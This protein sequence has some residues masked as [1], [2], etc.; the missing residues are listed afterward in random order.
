M[1]L[2]FISVDQNIYL[3]KQCRSRWG[4]SWRAVLSDPEII[5]LF[6]CSAQLSLKFSLLI[7]MKKSTI[8]GIFIFISRESFMLSYFS[9]KE[10]GMIVSNL[11]FISMKKFMLSWVE[12][13]KS[14]IT[15]GPDLRCLTFDWHPCL[16]YYMYRK[17]KT[18]EFVSVTLWR[19]DWRKHLFTRTNRL[20]MPQQAV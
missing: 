17:S 13:E 19:K 2:A 6:S 14:F 8:V 11:R 1:G 18:E 3:C 15:S 4:G 9:K 16:Q 5:K 7:N 12:H 10:F 20:D